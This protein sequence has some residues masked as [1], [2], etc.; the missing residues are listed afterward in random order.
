MARTV[1]QATNKYMAS[2]LWL[3]VSYKQRESCIED[4]GHGYGERLPGGG[5]AGVNDWPAAKE[6]GAGKYTRPGD[7]NS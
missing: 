4:S 2:K 5:Q 7:Q 6:A 3:P 1:K